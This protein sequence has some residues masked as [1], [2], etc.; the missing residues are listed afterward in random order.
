MA[1]RLQPFSAD[2]A[3]PDLPL[4]LSAFFVYNAAAVLF[5]RAEA[6]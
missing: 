3:A 2:Y 4:R 6:V 5:G 1:L